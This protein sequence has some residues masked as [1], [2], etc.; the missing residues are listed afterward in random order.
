MGGK[1]YL[2]RDV[3]KKSTSYFSYFLWAAIGLLF[4][5]VITPLLTKRGA[6][7]HVV[8]KV[9]P[10]KGMVMKGIP[11]SSPDDSSAGEAQEGV[12]VAQETKESNVQTGSATS[13]TLPAGE[14]TNSA[15]AA[16]QAPSMAVT[17][18]DPDKSLPEPGVTASAK[19]VPGQ[20][21]TPASAK[22]V[23]GQ[24]QTAASTMPQPQQE[25]TLPPAGNMQTQQPSA[26]AVD[27]SAAP[28]TATVPAT[29]KPSPTMQASA[30]AKPKATAA[31]RAKPPTPVAAPAPTLTA[32]ATP[33]T[34]TTSASSATKYVVQIGS[35]S[36][37]ENA[38]GIQQQLLKKGYEVMV[39]T[40]THEKFGRLYI[41]QLAPVSDAGKAQSLVSK[42][43]QEANVQ[44]MVIKLPTDQ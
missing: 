8:E 44:P 15:P 7:R 3:K 2:K 5:V 32:T 33:S 10:E 18:T 34:S 29:R 39:R 41:V 36:Q 12:K 23:P 9:T 25:Q 43:K 26:A 31:P 27:A 1:V 17:G 38:D 4:L 35:F 22:P 21:Q 13:P 40:V 24:M 6:E 19:P 11:K 16:A 42:V 20:M 28:A 30:A 14:A 37:R